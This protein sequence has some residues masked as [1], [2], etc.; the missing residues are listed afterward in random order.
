MLFNDY[1]NLQKYI[2][3]FITGKEF[4]LEVR[5]GVG[6]FS[7]IKFQPKI[8]GNRQNERTPSEENFLKYFL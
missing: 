5:L 2:R 6:K 3:A 8:I 7:K 1:I 4:G